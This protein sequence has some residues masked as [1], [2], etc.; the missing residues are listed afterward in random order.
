[1]IQVWGFEANHNF[2]IEQDF[3]EIY[4]LNLHRRVDADGLRYRVLDKKGISFVQ[5][6]QYN[7]T[8]QSSQL[9]K[10]SIW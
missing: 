3:R 10:T 8:A 2:C 6:M 9:S 7:P 4:D 5:N 1:M